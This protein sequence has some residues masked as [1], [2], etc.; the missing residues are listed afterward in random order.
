V[1]SIIPKYKEDYKTIIMFDRKNI[2][3]NHSF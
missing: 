1:L 3:Y 2:I